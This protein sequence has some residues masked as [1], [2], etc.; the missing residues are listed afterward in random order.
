MKNYLY[1]LLV[2]AVA[3]CYAIYL[4]HACNEALC[5]SDVSRCQLMESCNCKLHN[6]TC[7]ANCSRCLGSLWTECCDCVGLCKPKNHSHKTY[8]SKSSVEDLREMAIP[9]LFDALTEDGFNDYAERWKVVRISH[10]HETIQSYKPYTKEEELLMNSTLGGTCTV[11]YLHQ[12]LSMDKC[13]LTCISM[14]ASAYRWFHTNCCECI[15]H[16]CISYGRNEPM[17]AKCP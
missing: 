15:G 3:V 12:C 11:V 8:A 9:S 14:G 2:T 5:A 10:I 13:E 17:C 7:S 16:T 4:V 6:Y 1:P